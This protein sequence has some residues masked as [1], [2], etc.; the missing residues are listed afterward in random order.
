MYSQPL[1]PHVLKKTNTRSAPYFDGSRIRRGRGVRISCVRTYSTETPEGSSS[2]VTGG[3]DGPV[4]GSQP[5]ATTS[6][7][8]V[9]QATK[10]FPTFAS[11]GQYPILATQW[12]FR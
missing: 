12:P 4:E 7:A 5:A 6:I 10:H 8:I 9:A 1:D 3:V 2:N 11:M